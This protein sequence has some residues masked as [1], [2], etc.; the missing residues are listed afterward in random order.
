MDSGDPRYL[1]VG[2]H[3]SK[4]TSRS[5]LIKGSRVRVPDGSPKFS[6]TS[7]HPRSRLRGIGCARVADGRGCKSS[8]SRFTA[9]RFD[10]GTR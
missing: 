9:A 4:N 7:D 2:A 1:R 10:P 3:F 5:L 8:S 6:R